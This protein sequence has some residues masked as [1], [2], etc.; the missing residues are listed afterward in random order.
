MKVHYISPYRTD[1]NIGKAINEAIMGL[2]ASVDDWVVHTDQDVLWLLPDSKSQLEEIL[3]T[4][5][6]RI[7]APRMNRLGND[8][9]LVPGVFN[10]TDI[11]QHIA[12]AYRMSRENYGVVSSFAAGPLAAACL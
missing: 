5:Q 4:T 6:Y 3:L 2:N 10:V 12:L 9:Q 11:R 7:L 8:Y 1:K